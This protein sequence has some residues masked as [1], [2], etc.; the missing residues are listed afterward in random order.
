[1]NAPADLQAR[2]AEEG[3]KIRKLQILFGPWW[4]HYTPPYELRWTLFAERC[5]CPYCGKP[6]ELPTNE[7]EDAA[8]LLGPH[9]DH[10][11]PLAHGGEESV[12]NAVYS[13]AA[14]NMAKGKRLFVDWLSS[15]APATAAAARE[16]Y[17]AKHG[18]PPEAFVPG[19]RMPRMLLGRIELGFDEGVLRRLYPKPLV[20]GPPAR[21]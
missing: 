8:A 2:L 7:T 3:E 4:R 10:M 15:L 9:I 16:I 20:Q 17:V 13:C 6:L 19:A 1:M 21:M 18:H 12:R 11:D 5:A 14:C